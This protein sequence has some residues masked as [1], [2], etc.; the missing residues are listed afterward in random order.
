MTQQPESSYSAKDFAAERPV[1]I[2]MAAGKKVLVLDADTAVRSTAS[3][4]VSTPRAGLLAMAGPRIA[5]LLL[6]V[7]GT[8][9][10][11][12]PL[13]DAGPAQI[14][15]AVSVVAV[16]AGALRLALADIPQPQ[17]AYFLPLHMRS[18]LTFLEAL[19]VLA[20]EE[21]A[22]VGMLW[23]EVQHQ[24]RPWH[25]FALGAGLTAYLLVTHIAESGSAAGRLLRRQWKL[26]AVGACLLAVGAG[27]A[28]L[29]AAGEGAGTALLRVLAA[30]AVV[31]AAALVLPAA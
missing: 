1:D 16:T 21:T 25:T 15:L 10:A 5:A 18:W 9:W 7:A 8:V 19:R 20:W 22:V 14:A 13:G 3:G 11:A 30:V 4:A 17:D 29:P 26:L 6:G 23:L 27:F 2:R 12:T 31:V 28:M 24:V